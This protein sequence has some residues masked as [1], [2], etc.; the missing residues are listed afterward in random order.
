MALVIGSV[1]SGNLQVE[2]ST[3]LSGSRGMAWGSLDNKKPTLLV[4]QNIG[5]SD[6]YNPNNTVRTQMITIAI[7]K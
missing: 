3:E 4:Q 2:K 6:T 5:N 7:R 1:F